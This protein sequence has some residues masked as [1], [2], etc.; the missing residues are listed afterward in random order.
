[1]RPTNQTAARSTFPSLQYMITEHQQRQPRHHAR[2]RS[3]ASLVTHC[4]RSLHLPK[5]HESAKAGARSPTKH[6][7]LVGLELTKFAT[8]CHS[9][10]HPAELCKVDVGGQRRWS[11]I[12]KRCAHTTRCRSTRHTNITH[13]AAVRSASRL[14]RHA[15]ALPAERSES[16]HAGPALVERPGKWLP[17]RVAPEH[18]Y[19]PSRR[20]RRCA[21]A[22]GLVSQPTCR[23]ASRGACGGRTRQR[24]GV[25]PTL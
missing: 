8:A 20:C 9:L 3:P 21:S 15:E 18:V 13:K 7:V 16:H 2:V 6:I 19:M 22:V 23:F 11:L 4:D 17:L 10:A 24:I 25:Q 5:R 1:V 12:H 14:L